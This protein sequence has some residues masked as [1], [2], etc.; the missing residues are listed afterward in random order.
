MR[1]AIDS[2]V[3]E[4]LLID[5]GWVEGSWSGWGRG[6]FCEWRVVVVM[7]PFKLSLDWELMGF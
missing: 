4:D 3:M 2:R 1:K 7:G 6:E 5:R